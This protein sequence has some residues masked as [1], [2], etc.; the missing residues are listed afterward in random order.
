[1]NGIGNKV[2]IEKTKVYK[3]LSGSAIDYVFM[4]HF[5]NKIEKIVESDN[6][7]FIVLLD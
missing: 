3:V 7:I 2:E 6:Q 1:M 5:M 4:I